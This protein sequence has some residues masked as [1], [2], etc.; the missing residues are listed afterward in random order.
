MPVAFLKLANGSVIKCLVVQHGV[1]EPCVGI[2]DAWT[3]HVRYCADGKVCKE[4]DTAQLG[5]SRIEEIGFRLC[6]KNG[7]FYPMAKK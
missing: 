7:K 4:S 6:W 5:L 1:G 3:N 2:E